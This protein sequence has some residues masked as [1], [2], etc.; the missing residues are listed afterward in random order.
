MLRSSRSVNPQGLSFF[1]HYFYSR[2]RIPVYKFRYS[3]D[4]YLV[5]F[6]NYFLINSSFRSRSIHLSS[7]PPIGNGVCMI[8]QTTPFTPP[9]VITPN[10]EECDKFLGEE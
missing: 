10:S 5:H 3:I 7:L 4:Y 6:R 8:T 2:V 1:N 9:F